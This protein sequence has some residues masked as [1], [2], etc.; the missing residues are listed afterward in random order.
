MQAVR[1]HQPH[2][3][4]D[5]IQAVEKS[6]QDLIDPGDRRAIKNPLVTKSIECKLPE[7]F[8]KRMAC[9]SS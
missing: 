6:L 1:I 7:S 8:T 9:Q 4:I 3:I 2:K 5:L